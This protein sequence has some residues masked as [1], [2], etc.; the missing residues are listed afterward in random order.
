[1]KEVQKIEDLLKAIQENDVDKFD[2]LLNNSVTSTNINYFNKHR[3]TPLILSCQHRNIKFIEKVLKA[4]AEPS[5]RN[6]NNET[7]LIVVSK[8]E[9]IP[10]VY[11]KNKWAGYNTQYLK[12]D[13]FIHHHTY[14]NYLPQY[15][16]KTYHCSD[17]EKDTLN[18]IKL[19]LQFN[20]D[21][22][23]QDNKNNTPLL[24]CL[25]NN[26]KYISSY[27]I[28]NNANPFL[29][30]KIGQC[31]VSISIKKQEFTLLHE[32]IDKCQSFDNFNII[33]NAISNNNEIYPVFEKQLCILKLKFSLDQV[34]ET[35]KTLTKK[36]KI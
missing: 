4:G 10:Y 2:W 22:N 12:P 15:H 8:Q 13:Y 25:K 18:I 26:Y 30:N 6:F 35:K 21:I 28:E 7:A 17:F 19:L 1:M 20:S 23:A 11:K 16:K 27:L 34:L 24:Y 9:N 5:F 31:P 32:I 3:V 33:Y 14:D 29:K 36:P